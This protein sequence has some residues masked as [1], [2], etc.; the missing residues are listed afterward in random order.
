MSVQFND[1]IDANMELIKELLGNCTPGQRE[2]AKRAAVKIEAVV[3]AIQKDAQGDAANGLGLVFAV[4][5]I[6]QNMVRNNS[7]MEDGPRIQLLS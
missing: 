2:R 3:T 7:V 1:S 6:A 4:M 5:Y